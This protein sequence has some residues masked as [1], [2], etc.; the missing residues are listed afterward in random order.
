MLLL[1][2]QLRTL[3]RF[4]QKYVISKIKF[5]NGTACWTWTAVRGTHGYGVL[6]IHGSSGCAHKFA[7]EF[8]VGRIPD[9]LELDHLCKDRGCV[10]PRHLEPVTHLENVRRGSAGEPRRKITHCPKGHPYSGDNL[11]NRREG[12]RACKICRK[13]YSKKFRE[14]RMANAMAK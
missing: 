8:F 6:S 1:D 12:G 4:N 13:E 7:Y 14:N 9:G 10:N 2:Y 5:F 3:K 11:Y